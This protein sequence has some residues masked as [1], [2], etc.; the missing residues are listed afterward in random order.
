MKTKK[1]I[2]AGCFLLSGLAVASA[3]VK[4][5]FNPAKGTKY[6]YAMQMVQT[7]E[8]NAMGQKIPMETEMDIMYL[9]EI[10]NKTSQ[11]TQAQFTYRDISCII[12]SPVIKMGYDSKNPVENPSEMDKML[13]MI[14]STLIG[15]PF[16]INVAPD[17]SV[18][19]VTGM[20]AIA[21]NMTQAIAAGGQI[22]AQVGAS[23][24]Q[25][26]SDVA[27][28]NMF[29]QSLKI[30]PVNAVKPGDSWSV[31][32]IVTLS[33]MNTTINTKYTLKEVKKNEAAIA[34]EATVN[35][36]PGAG[37]EGSL[38]GT[39]IGTML[40]DVKTGM[41]VSSELAQ[42][43][44]GSIKTQGIDVSMDMNTKTT[45]STKEVK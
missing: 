12:S 28:K 35:M 11:E 18:K 19:S 6:E 40:V 4:L 2:V 38:S 34:M 21:E 26:F 14:F 13:D 31:E 30:Y 37:M 8:Q 42:N 36:Q 15:K 27:V 10:K 23:M 3:Q 5:S 41:P 16:T 43:I 17:G 39:Q 44:K 24:K 22:A 7:V 1:F 29:E 33:G 20:D 32:S 45:M 9:M 25:Q